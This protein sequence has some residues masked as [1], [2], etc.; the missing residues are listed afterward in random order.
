MGASNKV[1]AGR[2]LIHGA[3]RVRGLFH[4]C[5]RCSGWTFLSELG[6]RFKSD[7]DWLH[8]VILVFAV[9]L[10]LLRQI[11]LRNAREAPRAQTPFD[12]LL[13]YMP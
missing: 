4:G 7:G 12:R 10:P 3:R 13:R 6:R 2:A 9:M 5:S 8:A 1:V 11:H